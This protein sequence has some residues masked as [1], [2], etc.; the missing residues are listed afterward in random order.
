MLAI[1]FPH[2]TLAPV[3]SGSA[4]SIAIGCVLVWLLNIVRK[5][6]LSTH[7]RAFWYSMHMSG[8]TLPLRCALPCSFMHTWRGWWRGCPAFH[9]PTGVTSLSHGTTVKLLCSSPHRAPSQVNFSGGDAFNGVR[10]RWVVAPFGK[11]DWTKVNNAL[12]QP[13]HSL[14]S[15]TL[16]NCA[17]LVHA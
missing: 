16:R 3:H 4:S 13:K 5:A 8:F 11:P 6:M 1:V 14:Y 2:R 9:V 10:V 7:F 15:S 12:L 17:D